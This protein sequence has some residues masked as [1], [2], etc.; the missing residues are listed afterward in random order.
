MYAIFVHLSKSNTYTTSIKSKEKTP[1]KVNV[2][3]FTDPYS[4]K[5]VSPN[6]KMHTPVAV[7]FLSTGK[8][9]R[10]TW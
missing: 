3:E 8:V 7:F 2:I 1:Y 10:Y 5:K 6:L 9:A 4:A